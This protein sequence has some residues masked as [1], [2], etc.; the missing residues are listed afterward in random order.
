MSPVQGAPAL[1]TPVQT[2][3]LPLWRVAVPQSRE[4]LPIRER[5]VQAEPGSRRSIV[6]Q[7]A[8]KGCTDLDEVGDGRAEGGE[9]FGGG[10]GGE[11]GSGGLEVG[12]E[13]GGCVTA[14][15]Q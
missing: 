12:E 9:D 1:D 10:M 3:R 6:L 11:P 14:E 5:Q 8:I 7:P 13:K 15:G 4:L 2:R